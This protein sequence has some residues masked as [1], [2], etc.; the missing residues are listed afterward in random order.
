MRVGIVGVGLL[1]SA[2][3]RRLLAKGFEVA[4]HDLRR[5][6][7]T[8]LEPAGLRV[9]GSAREAVAGADCAFTILT[10]PEV[11]EQVWLAPGGLLDA[12]E[13]TTVLCQT[14]TI[15]PSLARRLGEAAAARGFRFLDTPISGTSTAVARGEA[16]LFVGG[17]TAVLETCRPAFDAIAA[18]TVHV[19]PVGAAS[20]AKLAAN[21]VGG[22]NAIALAEA[23]VLGAKAGLAPAA[24]L[25][26]LR[27]SPVRSGAMDARG[28]LMVSHRFDPHIRLD[29]FLKD[30]G[31]MLK[32]GERLGVPLP[33]TSVAH[34]LC[35]ATSAAG[36]GDEDLAAVITTLEYL[37]GIRS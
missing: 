12:A 19:G 24:L 34:Q 5:E 35:T 13:T 10:T 3:A 6:A 23:L 7:L 26:A 1:G 15:A 31:L 16:T 8:A 36:H 37:A 2:V 32:E 29:L 28:P 18:R 4:G 17:E 21:L 33:L 20:V 14:S 30:F 11:V 27:Q 22:I 25:E 9:A